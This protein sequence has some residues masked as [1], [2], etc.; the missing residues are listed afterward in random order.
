ME[1][2]EIKTLDEITAVNLRDDEV[3]QVAGGYVYNTVVQ[4]GGDCSSTDPCSMT[5]ERDRAG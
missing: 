4:S 2:K 1:S 5:L 3:E